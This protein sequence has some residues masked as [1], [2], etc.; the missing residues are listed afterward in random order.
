MKKLSIIFIFILAADLQNSS[1]QVPGYQ[2][3]RFSVGYNASSFFYITD[4]GNGN[5]LDGMFS[6]TTLSY[7]TELSVNYTVSRKTTMG[8]SYY[9]A[10]QKDNFSEVYID[11]YGSALPLEGIVS[12]KLAIYELHFQ[13]FR[14]NFVAPAGLYH[15]LSAGIVNYSLATADNTLTVYNTDNGNVPP[16]VLQG[17]FSP[18]SC[19]K[20]GYSIGKTNP[21]GHNFYINT[22]FGVNFFRGGDSPKIKSGVSASNYILANFN[23][24][25]RTHNFFEIKIGFGWLAF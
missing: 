11:N 2:G 10:K 9:F 14:K 25:L 4:F 12:C 7:K 1:A 3:K 13:F 22:A 15:Q 16:L 21:I 5:G 18:Y 17:S 23:R 24:N 19:F 6:S 20:L 8:F